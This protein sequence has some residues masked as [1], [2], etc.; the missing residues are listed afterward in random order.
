[1]AFDMEKLPY[2]QN[3]LEPYISAN[4]M[5]YHYGKHYKT[6][7]DNLNKLIA[8]SKFEQMPLDDIIRT[9][10]EKTEYTAIFNNA[11]QAWNHAFF[12][13]SMRPDGGGEPHTEL[14]KLLERDFGSVEKFKEEFKAAA[15]GQ[16]GSGCSRPEGFADR[17]CLGTRLLS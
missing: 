11:A 1:M 9:T 17:R 15:V 16:F 5:S 13:K 12:W 10:A 14:K 3:A 6:Y 2:E 7:I 8:G 4:T